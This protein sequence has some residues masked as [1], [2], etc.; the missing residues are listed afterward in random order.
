MFPVDA[1]DKEDD[2]KV[3]ELSKQTGISVKTLHHYDEMNLLN[4]SLRSDSGHRV[5]SQKD[6]LRL[7]KILTLKELGI[8]LGE[9]KEILGL[10]P[11]KVTSVFDQQFEALEQEKENIQKIS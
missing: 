9:I 8:S 6:L 1:N 3:G 7:Q 4:P 5:Y 2:M 11:P 10:T